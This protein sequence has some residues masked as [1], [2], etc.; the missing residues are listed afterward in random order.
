MEPSDSVAYYNKG[1]V[2]LGLK[3]FE[4][5]IISY[6]EKIKLDPTHSGVYYNKGKALESLKKYQEA[7]IC[8]DKAKQLNK[9]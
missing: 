2:L 6:D 5:A 8:Y 9:E 1:N 3:R 4:E 7:N